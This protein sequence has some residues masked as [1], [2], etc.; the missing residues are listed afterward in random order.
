[1]HISLNTPGD[2]DLIECVQAHGW[3][4]LQPF[5]WVDETSTLERIEEFEA[6]RTAFI[7]ISSV[8]GRVNAETDEAVDEAALIDRV[9]CMLQLDIPVDR[10]HLYCRERPELAGI[11]NLRQG[12]MLRS[13][14]VYEDVCKV[15]ATTNTTW[16]QTLGMVARLV[17]EFGT[18]GDA[19]GTRRAFPRPDRIASVSPDDFAAR[20]RMGYR[21]AAVHRISTDVA[22]GRLDLETLRD[23]SIPSAEIYRRMLALPG[24]GPYAASCLMIYLGRYDRVNVDSWAR[25]M[26]GKELGRS[27]T[28][29]EV[30]AFFEPYG[31]WKALVYHFYPWRHEAPPV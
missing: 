27:V 26:V 3:R 6:G 12:R 16:T 2:F 11:P 30:H 29:K 1:M 5:R 23:P 13:P 21:N 9:I 8:D 4:R 24:I 28:D 14:T 19:A 7:R 25:M 15:I 31:E 17:E 20:A 22:E 10:F 18:P